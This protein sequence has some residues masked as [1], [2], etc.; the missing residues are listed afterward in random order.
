MMQDDLLIAIM[1]AVLVV[2]N[3]ALVAV[4]VFQ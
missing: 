2:I 4:V 3:A 1:V